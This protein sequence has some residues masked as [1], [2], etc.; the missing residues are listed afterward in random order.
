MKDTSRVAW[1][2]GLLLF[3]VLFLLKQINVFPDYWIDVIFDFRNLLFA[4]GLILLFSQK[5]RAFGIVLISAGVL[6]YLKDIII[7]TKN[8]SDFIWPVLLISAG[9][10]LI[11]SA[12]S[13]KRSK[14][15]NETTNP[16]EE[17]PEENKES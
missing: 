3:G 6:F 13:K 15:S 14:P 11:S 16:L 4:F 17:Q 9:V 5:N 1:G 10:L 2:V 7:W 8:L 12:T